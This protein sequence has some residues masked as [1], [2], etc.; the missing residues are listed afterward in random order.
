MKKIFLLIIAIV[1]F[2]MP[3]VGEE[4]VDIVV[5]DFPCYDFARAVAGDNADITLLI[6][7]GA[8]VH[9]FDPTPAD[10][11]AM[12]EADVFAYIGGESDVWAE[13]ML[14]G[15]TDGPDILRMF[16]CVEE[17][18]EDHS[19]HEEHEHEEGH[20]HEY[21]EHIWTSPANA[22]LMVEAMRDTLVQADP[23]NEEI[24]AANAESYI[25]EIEKADARIRD[26]VE[27]AQRTELVFGDRFP[28]LYMA[29][30]YGL[31]YKAAFPGCAAE[32]EP[33]AKMLMELINYVAENKIPAVYTIEMSTGV[34]ARTIAD[35]TG[36]EVVTL[37][38]IQNVT[39]DEFAAGETYVSLMNRNADAL[40]KGLN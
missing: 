10:I 1:L 36:A 3:A 20:V 9:S 19:E 38:S 18:R 40:E 14:S 13:E 26:I 8:E 11:A 39:A 28:F 25:A 2:A 32:T 34:I 6:K 35:E 17:M 16:D 24:Y 29:Q 37:H 4:K 31:E 12:M 15:M 33:S 30:Y 7:P 22:V 23:A 21:D 5:T 27:N